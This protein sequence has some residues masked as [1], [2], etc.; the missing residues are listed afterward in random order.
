MEDAVNLFDSLLNSVFQ[1]FTGIIDFRFSQYEKV[2][3]SN[4]FTDK[5]MDDILETVLMEFPR[6]YYKYNEIVTSLTSFATIDP[7]NILASLCTKFKNDIHKAEDQPLS[8]NPYASMHF[9]ASIN[10]H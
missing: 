1:S 6:S 7:V 3:S 10:A 8:S 9:I 4:Q 5:Q 2:I